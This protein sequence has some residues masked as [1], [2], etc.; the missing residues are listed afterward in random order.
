MLSGIAPEKKGLDAGQQ[1]SR[2]CKKTGGG[3]RSRRRG[4][5]RGRVLR[6]CGAPVGAIVP[7][8]RPLGCIKRNTVVTV[9]I[10]ESPKPVVTAK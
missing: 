7:P 4:V 1:S 8:S 2:G 6:H 5:R 9:N 3:R 10:P